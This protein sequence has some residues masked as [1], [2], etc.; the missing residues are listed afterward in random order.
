MAGLKSEQ[1]AERE[2]VALSSV[3]AEFRTALRQEIDAARRSA[4]SNA[5][6]LVNGRRMAQ[7]GGGF[8]SGRR[9][10]PARRNWKARR[11]CAMQSERIWAALSTKAMAAVRPGQPH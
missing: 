4:S 11:I 8:W 1:W 5:V 9:L 7:I 6:G 3:R 10:L 2:E